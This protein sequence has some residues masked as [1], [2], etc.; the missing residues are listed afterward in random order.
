MT[1][2]KELQVRL[3][4]GFI[5]LSKGKYYVVLRCTASSVIKVQFCKDCKGITSS[6]SSE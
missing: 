6:R 1:N 5:N 2:K 4:C 3:V